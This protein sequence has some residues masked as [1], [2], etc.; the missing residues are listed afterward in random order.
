MLNYNQNLHN[1]QIKKSHF[2]VVLRQTSFEV[3][4]MKSILPRFGAVEESKVLHESGAERGYTGPRVGV[5][6]GDV[7][8][9]LD[10]M[11]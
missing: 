6:S 1:Y 11:P 2:Y 10:V 8:D 3:Y 9:I 5:D 4:F 7:G